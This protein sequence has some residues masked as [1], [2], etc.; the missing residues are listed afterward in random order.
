M[1]VNLKKAPK[2]HPSRHVVQVDRTPAHLRVITYPGVQELF[3]NMSALRESRGFNPVSHRPGQPVPFRKSLRQKLF[4]TTFEPLAGI[5]DTILNPEYDISAD[6][7]ITLRT[8]LSNPPQFAALI[9]SQ[10]FHR[11]TLLFFCGD[12]SSNVDAL[13][14]EYGRR[15]SCSSSY[16]RFREL[17]TEIRGRKHTLNVIM[18]IIKRRRK[19]YNTACVHF[20]ENHLELQEDGELRSKQIVL[21][22]KNL[23]NFPSFR[24]HT[25]YSNEAHVVGNIPQD[26][27]IEF[28]LFVD[29]KTCPYTSHELLEMLSEQDNEGFI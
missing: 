14:A 19:W 5:I 17:W 24:Y 29:I 15:L 13:Y 2:N 21:N 9:L 23:S 1:A 22:P 12:T 28:H 8:A 20:V 16:P 10:F 18:D 11:D 6:A 7:R 27:P 26:G 3:T 25:M 4:R